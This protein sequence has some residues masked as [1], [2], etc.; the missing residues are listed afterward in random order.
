MLSQ[1]GFAKAKLLNMHT[2]ALI[3]PFDKSLRRGLL[4]SLENRRFARPRGPV[5]NEAVAATNDRSATKD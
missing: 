3:R 4:F 2:K 1:S 5:H